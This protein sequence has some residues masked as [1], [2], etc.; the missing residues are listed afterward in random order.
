MSGM[1]EI[2]RTLS[3]LS[4]KM[5]VDAGNVAGAQ[6]PATR[7]RTV[8]LESNLIEVGSSG[9]AGGPALEDPSSPSRAGP[10]LS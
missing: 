1:D 5:E 7:K 10:A 9:T 2:G 4:Q 6:V 3:I 8:S